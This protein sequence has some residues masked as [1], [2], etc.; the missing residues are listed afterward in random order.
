MSCVLFLYLVFV[1]SR[2]SALLDQRNSITTPCGRCS[3][4][5]APLEAV[6][7]P[8]TTYIFNLTLYKE[9]VGFMSEQSSLIPVDSNKTCKQAMSKTLQA[10][11]YPFN[12]INL[13]DIAEF[14]QF[15]PGYSICNLT[16]EMRCIIMTEEMCNGFSECLSD[17]CGCAKGLE[18]FYCGDGSGCIAIGQVCDGV[19]D[20]L[21]GSDECVCND[22]INCVEDFG[23]GV[24]IN[25]DK[26]KCLENRKLVN[27]QN[28][29]IDACFPFRK[30]DYFNVLSEMCGNEHDDHQTFLDNCYRTCP[31]YK[32]HCNRVSWSTACVVSLS[33]VQAYLPTLSYTNV[34]KCDNSAE[35]M[36]IHDIHQVCD[37]KP[38]CLNKAD[39]ETCF[40]RF[41][42]ADDNRSIH[43]SKVCKV[44]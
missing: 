33:Q 26:R 30:S 38:D 41:I 36:Y 35:P 4:S 42:C 7:L 32:N 21:D 22:Y 14:T 2:A 23:D 13:D 31:G 27:V 11:L 44:V 20:C 3:N 37:G 43:I 5:T 6:K 18:T 16:A 8:P 17:E 19:R 15:H 1:W 34:Y 24:C 12:K 29:Q 9:L 25:S 40:N 28:P 39:E 10:R